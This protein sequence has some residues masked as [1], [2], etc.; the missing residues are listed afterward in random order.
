M[1]KPP[2]LLSLLVAALAV[3]VF[4]AVGFR[5]GRT[6]RSSAG[7]AV[8]SWQNAAA[9][10]FSDS[11]AGAYSR[12]WKRSY[13][14]GWEAGAIAGRAAGR[15]AGRAA[16][17]AQAAAGAVAARAVAAALASTPVKLTPKVKTAKCV[18]VAGGLCEALGPGIT[19]K[20]C[21]PASVADP[22]GGVVCV[23]RVLLIAGRIVHA[24]GVSVFT[25]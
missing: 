9:V 4:A 25:P 8:T 12:A 2:R 20:P 16:E 23:P 7:E 17:R 10:S 5:V 3:C 22:E 21:P 19:G 13:A 1:P 24:G 6:V 14:R 11:R 15:R 18:E